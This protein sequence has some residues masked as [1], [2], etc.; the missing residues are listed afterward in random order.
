MFELIW[1]AVTVLGSLSLLCGALLAIAAT[2]FHVETDPRLE[3]VLDALPGANCGACGF[4][5]CEA[6]GEA[7]L[8]GK[9]PITACLPGGE[10][11][12]DSLADILG[13]ESSFEE[14]AVA[15]IRCRGG[16]DVSYPRAIYQGVDSCK[17]AHA[18]AGG[19]KACDF[20][21]LGLS[22]CITSCPTN[23]IYG[24]ENRRRYVDPDRCTG[25]GICVDACPRDLIELVPRDQSVMP[26]CKSEYRG[27]R[28]TEKCSVACIGC[29]KCEK[30]C[31]FDAIKVNNGFA[32]ID[33][34]K[35]TQCAK[36]VEACP[37]GTISTVRLRG[38]KSTRQEAI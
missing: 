25:C 20:G 24:D 31:E 7:I 27:R 22:T 15:V 19:G 12:V 10:R 13:V 3:K 37:T 9:I 5:G 32:S 6:A 17:A 23:A 35:C 8:A 21:C 14:G 16:I 30:A 4:A 18:T 38:D 29:K 34:S 1:K 36:C 33:Y 2:R 11:T 28:A 26:F